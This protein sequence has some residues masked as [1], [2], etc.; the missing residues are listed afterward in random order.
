[1]DVDQGVASAAISAKLMF[2][3]RGCAYAAFFLT[4]WEWATTL[5]FETLVIWRKGTDNRLRWLYVVSRY[6][7]LL[8]QA[9]NAFVVA[10][11]QFDHF[12]S[13]H[14]CKMWYT[15]QLSVSTVLLLSMDFNLIFR[16]HALYRGSRRV[17]WSLL[18]LVIV[19]G[20]VVAFCG[21][22]TIH[23][24]T[25]S[26]DG[27]CLPMDAPSSVVYLTVAQIAT[28]FII[29]F[30]TIYKS[31]V[32]YV[33]HGWMKIPLLSLVARDG[34]WVFVLF[35]G[36]LAGMLSDATNRKFGN[37]TAQLCYIV[38]PVYVGVVSLSSCRITMNIRTFTSEVPSRSLDMR[39]EHIELTTLFTTIDSIF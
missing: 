26:G 12:V 30:M 4:L 17:T 29:W 37:P 36:L 21:S 24:V 1:M 35:T 22:S 25:F 10:F 16:L 15:F 18:A 31:L 33:E 3:V 20:I 19:E 27:G 2:V 6:V 39:T 13:Q 11:V 28:Q 8:A 7:G 38:F 14:H 34:F 5:N 9:V 32:L 23:S